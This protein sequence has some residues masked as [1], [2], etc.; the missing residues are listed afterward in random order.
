[1]AKSHGTSWLA[2][3]TSP[4]PWLI[5][6]VFHAGLG[7]MLFELSVLVGVAVLISLA[8]WVFRRDR[9]PIVAVLLWTVAITMLMWNG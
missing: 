7:V 3:S 9:H 6:R 8:V 2:S 1:M 4:P 5:A